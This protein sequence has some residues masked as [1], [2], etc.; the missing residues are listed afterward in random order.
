MPR[1]GRPVITYRR[2]AWSLIRARKFGSLIAP[3]D[4]PPRPSSPWQEAQAMA[5]TSRPSSGS[6]AGL[7]IGSG[8]ASRYGGAPLGAGSAGPHRFLMPSARMSTCSAVSSPPA[9]RGEGRHER[10]VPSFR[11]DAPQF[12]VRYLGQEQPVVQ[13]RCRPQLAV[14]PVATGAAPPEQ[15]VERLDLPGRNVSVAGPGPTGEVAAGRP[16]GEQGQQTSSKGDIR[17]ETPHRSA[18]RIHG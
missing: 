15:G 10:A 14:G 13:G 3:A 1:S 11:D 5:K 6:P 16:A 18:P 7:P 9:G 4:L 17:E 12:R 8:L 2:R